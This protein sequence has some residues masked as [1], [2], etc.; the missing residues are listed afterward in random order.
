MRLGTI[1]GSVDDRAFDDVMNQAVSAVNVNEIETWWRQM[2]MRSTG[3]DYVIAPTG[4]ERKLPERF[5]FNE[6]FELFGIDHISLT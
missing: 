6:L 3:Y 1:D 5:G 4:F 2:D